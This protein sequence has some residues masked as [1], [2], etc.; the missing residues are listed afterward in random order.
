ME[1]MLRFKNDPLQDPR[2]L[3][4]LFYPGSFPDPLLLP[5]EPEITAPA[6]SQPP[7]SFDLEGAAKYL[8]MTPRKLRELHKAKRV[9]GSRIDSRHY[10]FT[11]ADLNE[12]LAAYRSKP[13]RI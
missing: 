13:K 4:N 2:A 5:V 3:L 6:P 9:A 1:A 8:W 11:K 7:E 12:F 10:L